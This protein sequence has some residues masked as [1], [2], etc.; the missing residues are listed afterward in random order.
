MSGNDKRNKGREEKPLLAFSDA[1]ETSREESDTSKRDPQSITPPITPPWTPP[2]TPE[3]RAELFRSQQE[4][5]AAEEKEVSELRS[6]MASIKAEL[7]RKIAEREQ[8]A[9][10]SK[11]EVAK[12]SASEPKAIVTDDIWPAKR[13]ASN[14]EWKPLIDP[15][16]AIEVVKGSRK[17]LIATTLIGGIA[18]ALYAMTIPQMYVAS[19]DILVD[20]RSIK[21]VG[22]ELTPGQLPT[23]ASL[24]IAESQARLLDSSSVLLKVISQADLTKDPEFNG[25]FVPTG[26][27]GFFAQLK[28]MIKPNTAS[29]GQALET[30]VLYNLYD[31]LTIGRDAKTFIYS[32]SVKTRSPEKSAE[33][34]NLVGSVFQ[35]ELDS[36]QSDAARRNAEELS[37]RLADMRASVEKAEQATADFRA[38][39]DL[40]D[41]DG[42]LISDNDLT[43]LND[44]LTN[45][46][47][48]TVRLQARVQVL[49]DATTG[50]V[51]SGTLPE[52][53]RSNTLTALRAQ[54]A[55]ASQSA[56]GASTQ[57]G[58]RHPQ[59][60]QLQSQKQ[61]VLNDI[62][63]ELRRIRASL[64]VEVQRSAQQERDLNTR[65]AQ[66]KSQQANSN[67][68][69]VKLRELEREASTLRSVYEAFLLR[70]RE[71]TEQQGITTTNVRVISE[72]RPPLDPAGSSRKLIVIAGLIAGLLAGLAITAVRNFGRLVRLS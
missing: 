4:N 54:Y 64:Q 38:S 3:E 34:A 58:P 61:T 7:E 66:L 50:S 21:T 60:I 43:R 72:A 49:N 46:R 41:V 59:L 39:R 44:Q 37:K 10:L 62:D 5:K 28:S 71:T 8:S 32:I 25:S 19:T 13:D 69:R 40:V 18:A 42:K 15:R 12:V 53:L 55:L 24:A 16:I 33:I 57:L 51:I 35:T 23:D 6:R 68:D 9:S 31:S 17:L 45:Q 63:A 65:L 11:D 70:S 20:P 48:E 52:D 56:N 2:A 47:A 14:T 26:I 30:R 67:D 1:P 22:T 27:A 36:L 29:E